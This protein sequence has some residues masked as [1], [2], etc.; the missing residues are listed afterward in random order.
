[1]LMSTAAMMIHVAHV[2]TRSLPS[3]LRLSF[4][5]DSN[6]VMDEYFP[7]L[8]TPQALM[9]LL[10]DSPQETPL[11]PGIY[12][13]FSFLTTATTL[14]CKIIRA[15]TAYAM[16]LSPQEELKGRCGFHY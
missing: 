7:A 14:L 16:S 10:R 11:D 6:E 3:L 12:G 1:M 4:E 9:P 15:G 13:P 8:C 5:I 2:H